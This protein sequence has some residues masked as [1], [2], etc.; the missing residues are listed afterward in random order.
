[1]V[2]VPT[3]AALTR[4][5]V[6]DGIRKA[7]PDY[8]KVPGLVRKYFTIGQG[9]FGGIYL[10]TDKATAEAWFGEAW[11]ARVVKTYG[12]PATVTYFDVPVALDNAVLPSSI[13]AK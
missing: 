2:T 13:A 6:E 10:F 3:P 4:A 9:D 8:R 7:V 12:V 5:Q 1:M 11:K